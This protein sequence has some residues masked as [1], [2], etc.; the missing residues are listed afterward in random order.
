M[1]VFINEMNYKQC[2]FTSVWCDIDEEIL[3]VWPEFRIIQFAL[4]MELED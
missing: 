4:K 3:F 1:D 2:T